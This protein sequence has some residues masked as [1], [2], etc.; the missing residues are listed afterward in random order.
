MVRIKIADK[1]VSL[2]FSWLTHWK[3]Y[4]MFVATSL[5]LYSNYLMVEDIKRE[6]EL[7]IEKRK[8][9]LH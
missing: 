9:E 2:N 3:T 8:K 5:V 7:L 6:S 4:V 1:R